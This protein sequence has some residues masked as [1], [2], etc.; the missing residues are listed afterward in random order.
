MRGTG[1]MNTEKILAAVSGGADSMCLL[2]ILL[3][4]GSL[5]AVAHFNHGLR[6]EESDRDEEFV[7]SY[8]AEREI[9]FICGRAESRL[10]SE[11]EA[12]RARYAFLE[13]AADEAGC[14]LIATA[15]N[16]NDN[17]ETVLLNLVRGAGT[18]GLCGIP[19]RRGRII[20]PLLGM[21]RAEIEEYNLS[22]GIPHV[23]DSTNREND[24]SR[25]KIRNLVIPVLEEIN[26]KAVE[27][28]NR[29]S[30]LLKRDEE[31]FERALEGKSYE[32][33]GGEK[34]LESR[35]I[36]SRCPKALSFEQLEAAMKP[37]TEHKELDL[38]GIK[39]VKDG[40]RL[41]FGS[42]KKEY[43]IKLEEITVN[44]ELTNQLI[45]CDSIRGELTVGKWLPGDRMR[46]VGRN[47]SKSLKQLFLEKKL[48][49]AEKEAIPV[50]RDEKGI[51]LVPGIAADERARAVKG[52][53]AYKITLTEKQGNAQ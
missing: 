47:C 33:L 13:R 10:K 7:R 18:K 6:G 44:K 38:P 19:E 49:M 35:F 25:N 20:R 31:Y 2:N 42:E 15:H 24:F 32:E 45:K 37:E 14:A 39:L 8:C 9:K 46:P 27:A 52:D 16:M 51:L 3:E 23:E 29:A 17:A 22:R 36:M 48:T 30:V 4:K 26:P 50:I 43:E 28:L 12:R 1:K 21:T 53:R 34:A 5:G 40:G 11:D 41:L